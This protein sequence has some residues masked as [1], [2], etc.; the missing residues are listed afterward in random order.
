MSGGQ[1]L[2]RD[3]LL[4]QLVWKL[5]ITNR[6][7]RVRSMT[8][9]ASLEYPCTLLP[10]MCRCSTV[11]CKTPHTDARDK[12]NK[13]CMRLTYSCNLGGPNLICSVEKLLRVTVRTKRLRDTMMF[14]YGEQTVVYIYSD[15][16][17]KE[18]IGVTCPCGCVCIC[19]DWSVCSQ[20]S[21]ANLGHIT[22][23]CEVSRI[24]PAVKE[25]G[26]RNIKLNNNSTY[27]P[28]GK[29]IKKTRDLT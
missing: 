1:L 23:G 8:E 3:P 25:D 2:Q 29:Y 17:D 12:C 27:D 14:L 20:Q 9:I 18:A 4:C 19:C 28:C 15:L 21:Q 6:R 5:H 11:T 22:V 24:S 7:M 10:P 26:K 13:T 16:N